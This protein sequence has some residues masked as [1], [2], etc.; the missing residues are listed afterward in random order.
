MLRGSNLLKASVRC[1]GGFRRAP[2]SESEKDGCPRL[3]HA[4]HPFPIKWL[5]AFDTRRG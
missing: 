5:H 2:V 4:L 1:K 3:S